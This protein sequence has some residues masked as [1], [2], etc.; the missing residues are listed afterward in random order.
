MSRSASGLLVT[1]L[2]TFSLYDGEANSLHRE[3]R[4][5]I[6]SMIRLPRKVAPDSNLCDDHSQGKNAAG[7]PPWNRRPHSVNAVKHLRL[8]KD[9]AV[10]SRPRFC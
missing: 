9:R 1:V 3:H 4:G 5:L 8:R 2:T 7:P 10:G 6:N